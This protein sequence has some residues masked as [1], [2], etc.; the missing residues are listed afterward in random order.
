MFAF[1][2]TVS[3]LLTGHSHSSSRKLMTGW[4][5]RGDSFRLS[6]SVFRGQPSL[7]APPPTTCNSGR[8]GEGHGGGCSRVVRGWNGRDGMSAAENCKSAGFQE[9]KALC[10]RAS[11]VLEE[12]GAFS[13]R[14]RNRALHTA[15]TAW[16]EKRSLWFY[17]ILGLG[18]FHFCSNV[19]SPPAFSPTQHPM[20]QGHVTR[21]WHCSVGQKDSVSGRNHRNSRPTGTRQ[22]SLLWASWAK[23]PAWVKFLL[24]LKGPE[25]CL[26][27]GPSAA[28]QFSLWVI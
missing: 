11:G 16:V 8:L 20:G 10:R 17:Q 25:G 24:C 19:T 1:L 28:C 15:E 6:F 21:R 2:W 22:V 27:S 9:D 3:G 7:P 23:V 14:G 4:P 26:V 12:A 13:P 18:F 5:D